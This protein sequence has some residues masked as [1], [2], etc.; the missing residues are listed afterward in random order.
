MGTYE[1][2]ATS[3]S[4]EKEGIWLD[5]GDSG[6]FRI[7]RAGGSNR[8]YTRKLEALFEKHRTAIKIKNSNN[9]AINRDMARV[10]AEC[11]VLDWRD[12]TG[13]DKQPIEFSI[14]NCEKV[15]N[16]LP[17]LFE[18]IRETAEDYTLYRQQIQEEDSGNS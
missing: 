1:N 12:V 15:L 2:F 5:L 13:P 7:A 6:K 11:V 3:E 17:K 14:L 10:Y 16:D 4:I 8:E 18:T 9:E